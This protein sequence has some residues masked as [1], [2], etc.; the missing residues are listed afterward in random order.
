M[1]RQDFDVVITADD[2]GYRNVWK[3]LW[4]YRN[5]VF[6]MIRRNF[7]ANYKQTVLGPSWAIIQP[8]VSTII[9]AVVFGGLAGLSPDGIPMFLFYMS[10]Q[11][12]WGFFSGC[13]N[14]VSTTFVSNAGLMGKVYFPRFAMPIVGAGTNVISLVIQAAMFTVFY[15]F[16]VLRGAEISLHWSAALI[17]LY[18]LQLAILGMGVGAVLSAMTTKY[19]DTTFLI[20]YGVT[21][22]MYLTPVVY[23]IGIV[24]KT[25][26]WLYM[27]NPVSPVI[28]HIRYALFQQGQLYWGYYFLSIGITIF[29]LI[30]GSRVFHKVERTFIDIV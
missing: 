4:Q 26:M 20:S 5:M 9:T 3:E 10:G 28:T 22:W 24:P 14:N 18:L 7:V 15:I 25:Y 8:V 29:F 17:P 2:R 12:T 6:Q 19:R 11:L 27:I 21:F 23:D 1:N 16:F 30:F 13:L